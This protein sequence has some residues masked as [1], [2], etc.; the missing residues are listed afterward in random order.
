ML[1]HFSAFILFL[2]AMNRRHVHSLCS[3]CGAAGLI[4]VG[5]IHGIENRAWLHL[6]LGL[7]GI[8]WPAF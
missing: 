1:S 3:L 8:A 5:F 6:S 7:V 4:S 2:A